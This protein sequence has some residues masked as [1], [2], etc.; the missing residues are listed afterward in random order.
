ML[1]GGTELADTL[2]FPL[3]VAGLVALVTLPTSILSGLEAEQPHRGSLARVAILGGVVHALL[4]AVVGIGVG[5]A[6]VLSAPGLIVAILGGAHVFASR[7]FLGRVRRKELPQWSIEEREAGLDADLVPW[8]RRSEE[9]GMLVFHPPPSV[10]PFRDDG[11]QAVAPLGLRVSPHREA[12]ASRWAVVG[13]AAVLG[14]PGGAI[15][16]AMVSQRFMT[17]LPTEPHALPIAAACTAAL[18]ALLVGLATRGAQGRW[19]Q[20]VATWSLPMGA[21]NGAL[22][23]VL[24]VEGTIRWVV[25]M[26]SLLASIPASLLLGSVLTALVAA[27]GKA[28]TTATIIA[29]ATL[30]SAL[31]AGMLEDCWIY[32]GPPAL[33]TLALGVAALQRHRVASTPAA[34]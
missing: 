16:E 29:G 23:G 11:A 25:P 22:L 27:D 26:F 9:E 33:A 5:M 30:M 2:Y 13:L 28:G 34:P 19:V 6:G 18:S 20:R 1:A 3:T 14:A 24:T 31:S 21:L 8:S 15:A 10:G 32:V 4:G 7:S 12:S 17:A